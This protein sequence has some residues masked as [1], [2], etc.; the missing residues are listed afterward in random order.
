MALPCLWDKGALLFPCLSIYLCTE[1]L[2]RLRVP[3]VSNAQSAE[4]HQER[5]S[6][7]LLPLPEVHA[8]QGSGKSLLAEVQGLAQL[9]WP[10]PRCVWYWWGRGPW[11]RVTV[12]H[13]ST[14]QHF[15]LLFEK[16]LPCLALSSA[17]SLCNVPN[18][19][20]NITKYLLP[21]TCAQ[22]SLD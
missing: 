17:S 16:R 8:V 22:G 4:Y 11:L 20:M 7:T 1:L 13:G 6:L 18:V 2:S 5:K 19:V 12:G 10:W 15:M 21:C 3:V 14:M 9:T